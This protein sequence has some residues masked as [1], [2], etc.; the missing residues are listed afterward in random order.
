MPLTQDSMNNGASWEVRWVKDG[1]V[2]RKI[3]GT[4]FAGALGRYV[5]L[6]TKGRRGVTLRCRNVGFPPP[7]RITQHEVISY[8]K[9]FRGGKA[10]KKKIIDHE[11]LMDGHNARGIF[12]CPY[13]IKL[14]EFKRQQWGKRI[15][16]VCPICEVSSLD[17]HVKVHNPKAKELE[18]R[19]VRTKR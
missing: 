10:Y 14:L 18:F 15:V 7:L 4:D 6:K 1:R 8:K 19:R 11:N 17:F 12:W 5:A 9:V 3:Y 16:V 13:C 2:A